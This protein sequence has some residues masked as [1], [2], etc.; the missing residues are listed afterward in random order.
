MLHVVEVLYRGRSLSTNPNILSNP[1]RLGIHDFSTGETEDVNLPGRQVLTDNDAHP[2]GLLLSELEAHQKRPLSTNLSGIINQGHP[3][4]QTNISNLGQRLDSSSV[5]DLR[6]VRDMWPNVSSRHGGVNPN[7]FHDSMVAHQL[8]HFEQDSGRLGLEDQML[9]QQLQLQQ[10]QQQNLPT[11]HQRL[12]LEQLHSPHHQQVIG[13]HVPEL[14]NL[15]KLQFQQQQLLQLQ[16]QQELQ[17]LPL[18]LLEQRQQQQNEQ[19]HVQHLLLEQLLQ[20][21]M[22]EPPFGP[23]HVEPLQRKAMHDELV[24][25]ERLHHHLKQQSLQ[26]RHNDPSLEQ[27]IQAKFGHRQHPEHPKDLLEVL[28]SKQNQGLLDQQFFLRLQQEQ[29]QAQ[30]FPG[31]QRQLPV[32]EDERHL[33][34]S[35]SVDESG[36]LVRT[37]SGRHWSH[38]SGLAQLDR[39]QGQQNRPAFEQSGHFDHSLSMREHMQHALFEPRTQPFERP[40][41]SPVDATGFN[42]ELMSRLQGLGLQ[43][44]FGNVNHSGQAGQFPSNVRSRPQQF[45]NQFNASHMD[46]VAIH[47]SEPDG[48]F[49]KSLMESQPHQLRLEAERQRI[50]FMMNLGPEDPNAWATVGN[51]DKSARSLMGLLGKDLNIHSLPPDMVNDPRDSSHGIRDANWPFSGPA[52]DYPFNLR[53]DQNSRD[54][55]AKDPY[56]S[57]LRLLAQ[58]QLVN[59]APDGQTNSI[60]SGKRLSYQPISGELLEDRQSLIMNETNQAIYRD[61]SMDFLDTKEGVKAKKPW[62]KVKSA[63][64]STP[65]ILGDVSDNFFF[66]FR[67]SQKNSLSLILSFSIRIETVARILSLNH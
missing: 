12:H 33:G 20:R 8:S 43:D 23:S 30:Q 22:H 67:W 49:P 24:F 37:P 26:P 50:N 18:Q 1:S 10:L 47:M 48:Q 42:T 57:K 64:G 66:W 58:E 34:R 3:E 41:S 5:G 62:S 7:L 38:S 19:S 27:L 59:V 11:P 32:V 60:E 14:E 21:Q 13:P 63:K 36:Q 51:D 6:D 52:S 39:L 53:G 29:L 61:S 65:E 2:L 44:Q 15:L 31:G 4:L 56:G 17:H 16:Q 45:P 35:W 25:Q 28:H 46:S 40:L 54:T 9:L 55:F